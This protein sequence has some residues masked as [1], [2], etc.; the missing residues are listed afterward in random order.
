MKDIDFDELD[1]AVNRFLSEDIAEKVQTVATPEKTEDVTEYIGLAEGRDKPLGRTA[2]ELHSQSVATGGGQA[3]RTGRFMDIMRPSQ[4]KAASTSPARS[5]FDDANPQ[6]QTPAIEAKPVKSP[7][8]LVENLSDNLHQRRARKPILKGLNEELEVAG[9]IKYEQP[10]LGAVEIAEL[11]KPTLMPDFD[12][13]KA[14]QVLPAEDVSI[15]GFKT[16]SAARVESTALNNKFV[17]PFLT[18][19]RLEK[20]DLNDEIRTSG[21]PGLVQIEDDDDILV[22]GEAHE[23]VRERINRQA[24]ERARNDISLRASAEE[25]RNV[26]APDTLANNTRANASHLAE[27][28]RGAIV[29]LKNETKQPIITDEEPEAPLTTPFLPNARVEKR[30]L[31]VT[32]ASYSN[33]PENTESRLINGAPSGESKKTA[34]SRGSVPILNSDEYSS[35][36][37][38]RPK[39]KSGWTIVLAILGIIIVGALGGLLARYLLLG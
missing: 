5:I 4:D 25:A 35:P 21:V 33:L 38:A 36:I 16:Q 11:P 26:I 6:S 19:P 32:P 17:E 9:S 29:G 23:T 31:G 34:D 20:T 1:K 10:V 24:I 15:G 27:V 3:P 18:T 37:I 2:K 7:A 8:D 39:K 28:S 14:Q 22:Y 13:L 30:P 12:A